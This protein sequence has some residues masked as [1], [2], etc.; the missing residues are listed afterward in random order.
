MLACPFL[1][2]CCCLVAVDETEYAVVTSFG[3]IVAVHGVVPGTAGLH[4]KGPWQSVL[5]VDHR[6][7]AFD[8][9]PR[10]VITGDKRNLEVAS[11]LIYRVADPVQLSAARVRWSRPKHG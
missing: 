3:R 5:R 9:P 1:L 6:L 8:P 2:G 4:Y 7:R 10:E 11:Y